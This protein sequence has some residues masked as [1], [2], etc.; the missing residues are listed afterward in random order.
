MVHGVSAPNH[1]IVEEDYSMNYAIIYNSIIS[2]A[3]SQARVKGQGVYYEKHHILPKSLGGSNAIDN[4]VLLTA[5]E[6]FVAHHLLAKIHGGKMWYAFNLMCHAK[7]SPGQER[8]YTV[9]PNQYNEAKTHQRELL[10][11]RMTGK[12]NPMFGI[13]RTPKQIEKHRESLRGFRHSEETRAKMRKN[14][15]GKNNPMFGRAGKLAPNYGKKDS[16]ETRDRRRTAFL[17]VDK[18]KCQ[19]CRR[20]FFPSHLSRWHGENCKFKQQT[21]EQD[22]LYE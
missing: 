20:E 17:N 19:Y 7:S 1:S 21:L 3:Q 16:E 15:A 4:L 12:N 5:K 8:N 10:S 13:S 11:K 9:T 6:H 22:N 14:N 2:N 18:V